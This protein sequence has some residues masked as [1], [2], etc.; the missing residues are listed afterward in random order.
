MSSPQRRLSPWRVVLALLIVTGVSMGSVFGVQQW[1]SAQA[2]T[3]HDPWFASYVDVTA[4]PAFA[5]E[6]MS[7]TSKKDVLLSF[8]VSLPSDACTPA[9]G[10]AYTLSQASASLDLDR[11]VERLRQQDGSV[12]VSFG[13]LKNNE[14]AVTCTDATKLLGAYKSVIDRYNINTIDLDLEKSGLT[15]A[16]AGARRAGAIAKLQSERRAQGKNLAVWVTLPVAPQG[17]SEDGTNAIAQLLAKGVDLAGINVMTMDYGSSRTTGQSMLEA[18][19]SALTQTHR[20]LGALY[21]RASTP[22]NSATLW[23]KIGATPMIGQNDIAGEVFTL[24]D[25]KDLNQF[26][27]S[28]AVGRMSMWSANRDLTCSGNYVSLKVVSDSCSGVDQ[29]KQTFAAVLSAG[30]KGS[31]SRSAGL[32]TTADPASA[33]QK[34]DNPKTS[35]YQIWSPSGAYLKGTKVVWHHNV[36]EAKWWTEGDTPDS[37]VLQTWQTPWELVGPVLPGEKPIAQPTLPAGAY[38]DWSGTT[39]YNTG[40]RVLFSGVPYQAKWWNQGNSPAAASSNADGSP[41]VPLTQAQ[42]NEVVAGNTTGPAPAAQ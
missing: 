42:I 8:I 33:E 6:Q 39:G 7:T 29:G 23:S 25:A 20:Q 3:S 2:A 32:A 26:A 5:F 9:W 38:P 13:G 18:S 35:P 28:H 40:Q 21:Q 11:R 30:F 22:L 36:Y 41:W 24:D 1:Q 31:L 12:A 27:R 16:N 19:K 4:T 37:P 10:G 34:P 15:D 17:L 14:L